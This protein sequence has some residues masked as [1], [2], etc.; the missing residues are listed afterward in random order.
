MRIGPNRSTSVSDESEF[1]GELYAPKGDGI[2]KRA[3]MAALLAR[4]TIKI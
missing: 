1:N 3:P 2:I 4:Y